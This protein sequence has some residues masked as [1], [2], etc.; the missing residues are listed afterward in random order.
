[1]QLPHLGS[2]CMPAELGWIK[3]MA[4]DSF[5]END[6]PT[7]LFLCVDEAYAAGRVKCAQ[8]IGYP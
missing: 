1:M 6:V 8:K 3:A 7:P 5:F 2:I 4:K